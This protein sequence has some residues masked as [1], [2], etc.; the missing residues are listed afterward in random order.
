[1]KKIGDEKI[2]YNDTM[3]FIKDNFELWY[4]DVFFNFQFNY[5]TL[6]QV[7]EYDILRYHEPSSGHVSHILA[8]MTAYNYYSLNF[9]RS[10]NI[11]A[12]Q[13]K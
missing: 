1:M 8:T 7:V 10:S 9:K 5:R 13:T 11:F 2:E 6:L 3:V 4:S 12:R